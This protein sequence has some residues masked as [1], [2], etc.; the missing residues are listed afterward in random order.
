MYFVVVFFNYQ[1]QNQNG[2][3]L[4]VRNLDSFRL[5]GW[6]GGMGLGHLVLRFFWVGGG[7][8]EFFTNFL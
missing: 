4:S 5:R 8:V 3:Y 1:G 2:V 6:G 7:G